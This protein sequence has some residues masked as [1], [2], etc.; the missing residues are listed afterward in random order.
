VFEQEIQDFPGFYEEKQKFY[1]ESAQK[2]RLVQIT[3]ARFIPPFPPG[4][5][6]QHHAK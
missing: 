5:R 2:L 1:R 6:L 4:V 3:A